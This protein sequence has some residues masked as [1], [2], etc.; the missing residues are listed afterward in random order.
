MGYNSA[1]LLLGFYYI[2]ML[3]KT[4]SEPNQISLY[5]DKILIYQN[6]DTNADRDYMDIN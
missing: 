1:D 4:N 3:T 2:R 5:S 6:M